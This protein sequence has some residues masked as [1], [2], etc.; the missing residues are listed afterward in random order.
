LMQ[1]ATS[2]KRD[3]A[4]QTSPTDAIKAHKK[5]KVGQAD[6]PPP[7]AAPAVVPPAAPAKVATS[8]EI[9]PKDLEKRALVS[10]RSDMGPGEKVRVKIKGKTGD[11]LQ[12][13][14]F[15]KT[16]EVAKVGNEDAQL[17][18]IKEGVPT[19][20]YFVEATSGT[21]QSS[22][23]IFVGK[24]DDEFVKELE[25]HIKSISL[26]QQSEKSAL[27]YGALRLEKLAKQILTDG[28]TLKAQPL[29]WKKTYS[30]WKAQAHDANSPVVTLAQSPSTDIAYPEQIAAF[31]AATEK[32]AAQAKEIDAAVMQKRDVASANE[33]LSVEFAHLREDSA[34]LSGRPQASN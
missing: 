17:D 25:R 8:L 4:S 27:F 30:A 34:K 21:A 19:G 20:L 32:L 26:R 24:R 5:A 9:I 13:S 23:E 6:A 11:I 3:P 31:Q 16:F 12:Y 15:M 1:M 29:K 10:F 7:A 14:S 33:D 2:R 28:Q 18:L 22:T